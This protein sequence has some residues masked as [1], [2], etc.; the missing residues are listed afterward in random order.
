MEVKRVHQSR[1][2]GPPQIRIL[3]HILVARPSEQLADLGFSIGGI[4]VVTMLMR[5]LTDC[6][7]RNGKKNR[8]QTT[9]A[10]CTPR[11]PVRDVPRPRS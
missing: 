1:V 5:P 6:G 7:A 4:G 3:V 2:G 8:N 9:H 10:D 11:A